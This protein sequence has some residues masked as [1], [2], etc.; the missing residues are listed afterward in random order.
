M[1]MIII[2]IYWL[3]RFFSSFFPGF[4]SL[5]RVNTFKRAASTTSNLQSSSVSL[6]QNS[7]IRGNINVKNKRIFFFSCRKGSR[8]LNSK[9]WLSDFS[10]F[11]CVSLSVCL[12]HTESNFTKQMRKIMVHRFRNLPQHF[13]RLL[14]HHAFC[15]RLAKFTCNF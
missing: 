11:L 10:S 13:F 5:V 12:C 15:F 9:W 4:W 8:N 7:R 3:C 2:I 1:N 14:F 6:A